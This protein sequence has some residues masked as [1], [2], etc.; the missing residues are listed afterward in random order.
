MWKVSQIGE[1]SIFAQMCVLDLNPLYAVLSS[2]VSF[3]LP[4]LTMI[5]IYA[6]MH[7]YARRHAESIKRDYRS[8]ASAT[9][10]AAASST[11]F[12]DGRLRGAGRSRGSVSSISGGGYR[13][14]D[15][16]VCLIISY[17]KNLIK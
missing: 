6:H 10:A 4:C 16:K 12:P 2:A 17:A 3:Y 14:S 1:D 5:V 9:T 11:E 7:R 8:F 13:L 15:H